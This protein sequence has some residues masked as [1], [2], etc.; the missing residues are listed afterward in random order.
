MRK[1]VV[2]LGASLF[3]CL[4]TAIPALADSSLPGP[5][6]D[7]DVLGEAGQAGGAAGGGTAFTGANITPFMI[8]LAV[9]VVV[10]VSLLV[11]RQRRSAT[12]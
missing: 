10:G 12:G 4:V 3:M 6:G 9:L 7:P 1:T 8:A 2:T 5:G 11:I